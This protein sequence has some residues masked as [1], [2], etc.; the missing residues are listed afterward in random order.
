MA[1][2]G[3]AQRA[4]GVSRKGGRAPLDWLW[5]GVLAVLVTGAATGIWSGLLVTNLKLSPAIPWAV[6]PMALVLWLGW[7]VLGGPWGLPGVRP[8]RAA[9]LRAEPLPA[10]V[11]VWAI[12]A[13]A[14]AIVALAGF[15]IVLH[16]LVKTPTNPLAQV[17]QYPPLTVVVALAMAS[18]SGGVSEEAGF[19]GYFQGALEKRGLGWASVAVVAL[20]MAPIHAET[21]GFV[22]PNLVFYLLVDGMLGALAYLTK[23]I[24]PGIVVHALGLF[25]FFAIVWPG[26][27]H[28]PMFAANAGHAW[29]WLHVAQALAFT[30]F[31]LA[32]F[33]KLALVTRRSTV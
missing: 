31:S 21:Q 4:S 9:R 19:R 28:R 5:T 32:A 6:A 13:G 25:V 23:S 11:M 29:F 20:V 3:T 16:A 26:D 24:R 17:S 14:C 8:G 27:A 30:G 22:W 2:A 10:P 7:S 15:W 18:I 12:A 33:V 1:N